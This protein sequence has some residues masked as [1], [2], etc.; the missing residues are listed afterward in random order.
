M[1]A[2]D[3]K[4]MLKAAQEGDIELVRYHLKM[5]IDPNYQHPEFMT[6]PLIESIRFGNLSIAK[7]LL[8]H[9]ADPT[10]KEGFGTD[11]PLS[12]ATAA[13]NKASIHLLNQYLMDTPPAAKAQQKILVTG[14]NRG[15]G[16]A[17]AQQLLEEGHQVMITARNEALAKAVVQELKATTGNDQIDYLIGDLSNIRT[18]R[19]LAAD[20]KAAFPQITVLLN[21]AG[22]WMTEKVLNEDGLE[23]SFM[24]NY[25]APYILCQELL[26]LLQA[27]SP[28]RIVNVNAG[29][30]VKGKLDLERTPW[31]DDFHSIKTY[32]TSKLCGVLFNLSFARAIEG[33]G[34]SI[35]SVHR[36][37]RA[38]EIRRSC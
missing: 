9:G 11:T 26:P 24:T 35:N 32:A 2:G 29:L 18:S 33:S 15:I 30:Y 16:K 36:S 8:E 1:S 17:I 14:G 4:E 12:I 31:G 23:Q 21:N 19:Q 3:W 25:L 7:L 13:N 6:G 28:A 5:G 27:N 38:W 22:V 37:I 10:I 34:V 20:I